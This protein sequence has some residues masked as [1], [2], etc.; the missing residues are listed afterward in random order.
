MPEQFL[1]ICDEIPQDIVLL[2]VGPRPLDVA[3]ALRPLVGVGLWRAMRR[4]EIDA[5]TVVFP[6]EDLR[7]RLHEDLASVVLISESEISDPVPVS[8]TATATN[9]DGEAKGTVLVPLLTPKSLAE[10][11]QEAE[12]SGIT[13]SSLDRS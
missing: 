5:S 12:A 1:L 8:W 2:N 3:K 10:L 7:V 11:R 6:V 4:P 9:I 13:S